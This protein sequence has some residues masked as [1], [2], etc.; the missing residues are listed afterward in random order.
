MQNLLI[1]GVSSFIGCHLAKHLSRNY[2]VTGTLSQNPENYKGIQKQRLDFIK[3][4]ILFRVMNLK[5]ATNVQTLINKTKPD[6]MIHHAGYAKNY[7]SMDYDYEESIKVNVT[8]LEQIYRSLKNIVAKGIVIT[9][10]CMEYSNSNTPHH[11]EEKCDPS[12]PYGKSK[13]KETLTALKL[14]KKHDIPTRIIRVFNPYGELEEPGKLIPYLL[15]SLKN[16]EWVDLTSCE[17]IRNFVHVDQ[18]AE[19]YQKALEDLSKRGGSIYNGASD[20]NIRLKDFLLEYI[21]DQNYSSKNLNFG[22][23]EMRKTE[24]LVCA[25]S[26]DKIRTLLNN[27]K[28]L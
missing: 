8:P 20:K 16:K 24:V 14:S 9:G 21:K 11:E 2:K 1:T 25:A 27:G 19:L 17:Q 22:A 6:Y 28:Q 4:Q 5:D 3:D 18:L 13:L 10:T 15:N 12:S 7:G 23:K 26:Y